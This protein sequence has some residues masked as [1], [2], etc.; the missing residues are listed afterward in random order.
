MTELVTVQL[1]GLPVDLQRRAAEHLDGLRRE[2]D[3]LTVV[4]S[5]EGSVPQRL[6]DLIAELRDQF[7]GFV[8]RPA[9]ELRS[10]VAEGHATMDL[11]YEVP[12]AVAD[13][14]KRL[15]ELLDEADRFCA[16]GRALVT[17]ATPHDELRYRRWFLAE[18]DQQIAGGEPTPWDRYRPPAE[19]PQP[20]TPTG[21]RPPGSRSSLRLEGELDLGRAGALLESLRDLVPDEHGTVCVDLASVTFVDS[22]VLSALVAAHTRFRGDGATLRLV[23]DRRVMRTMQLACLD[24]VLDLELAP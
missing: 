8:A 14:A 7:G 15:G 11:T 19:P 6:L 3:L 16:S 4:G 24:E 18:F 21:A 22:A 2:F 12:P 20:V 5:P 23:V 1:L 13:A 10:A 9:S 17:M